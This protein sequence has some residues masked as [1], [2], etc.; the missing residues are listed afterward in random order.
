MA[1]GSDQPDDYLDDLRD[2]LM[3]A[4]TEHC[5]GD[6]YGAVS[7]LFTAGFTMLMQMVGPIHAAGAMKEIVTTATKRMSN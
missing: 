6:P 1:S 4:A 2:A 7:A 5:P 3:T